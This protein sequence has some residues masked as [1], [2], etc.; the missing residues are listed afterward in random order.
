MEIGL[1]LDNQFDN[2]P[3]YNF[4]VRPLE[5]DIENLESD[6]IVWSKS[7]PEFAI[8]INALGLHVPLF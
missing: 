2:H 8:F 7:S 1:N 6:K 4:E 5:F 3:M